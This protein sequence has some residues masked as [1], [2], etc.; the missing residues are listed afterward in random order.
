MTASADSI[1]AMVDRMMQELQE[2]N[3]SINY[4]QDRHTWKKGSD[5]CQRCGMRR[6]D[7]WVKDE[8]GTP[9]WSGHYVM[10]NGERRDLT[11]KCYWRKP[12]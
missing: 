10:P 9:K 2:A 3:P 5:V 4:W 12:R 6:V 7:R 8:T 11:G 1:G